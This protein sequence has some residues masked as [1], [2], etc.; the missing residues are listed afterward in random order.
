MTILN[1]FPVTTWLVSD[2]VSAAWRVE[3]IAQR[4]A[5]DQGVFGTP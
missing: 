5:S 2:D 3:T 4:A 1:T